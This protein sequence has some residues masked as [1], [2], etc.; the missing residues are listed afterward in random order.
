M[1]RGAHPAVPV[2]AMPSAEPFELPLIRI[3]AADL[4]KLLGCAENL[5]Q[6]V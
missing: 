3:V 4:K 1:I 5:S 2:V 6:T